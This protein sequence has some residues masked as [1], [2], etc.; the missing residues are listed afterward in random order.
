MVR[1][2]YIAVSISFINVFT[3][4][5][6]VYASEFEQALKKEEFLGQESH[7]SAEQ[8]VTPGTTLN[9]SPSL[10]TGNDID[11]ILEQ[12]EYRKLEILVQ[13]LT[14]LSKDRQLDKLDKL[15][16]SQEKFAS[17]LGV[18]RWKIRKLLGEEEESNI[19]DPVQI[20]NSL[21][22]KLPHILETYTG[23]KIKDALNS[24]IEAEKYYAKKTKENIMQNIDS[25]KGDIQEALT[26]E[27]LIKIID[28]AK[29]KKML[30]YADASYENYWQA[31][32]YSSNKSDSSAASED[33]ADSFIKVEFDKWPEQTWQQA[34]CG[35]LFFPKE[36]ETLYDPIYSIYGREHIHFKL[37]Y[38]AKYNNPLAFYHLYN[39]LQ[40]YTDILEPT[41]DQDEMVE[42]GTLLTVQ[43]HFLDEFKKLAK[44]TEDSPPYI[45]GLFFSWQEEQEKG[46]DWFRKA[47]L[48]KDGRAYYQLALRAETLADRKKHFEE[49]N[50]LNYKKALLGI[51]RMQNN[52]KEAFDKYIEAGKVGIAEGYY[53]TAKTV[54]SYPDEIISTPDEPITKVLIYLDDAAEL[55]MLTAY[56]LAAELC[57]KKD[58]IDD[59]KKYFLKKGHKG[60]PRGFYELGRLLENQ[61]EIEEAKSSYQQSERL[62]GY[63]DAARLESSLEEAEKLEQ[64]AEEYYKSHF[65]KLKSITEKKE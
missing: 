12:Y 39:L 20:W 33:S 57:I 4:L 25:I 7:L 49:A 47:C 26:E 55:G 46:R 53:Q 19:K 45:V 59:A 32:S 2:S 21:K 52:A 35:W 48:N 18:K 43:K 27:G 54:M 31:R 38:A 22:D 63:F 13:M 51:A 34:L 24:Y 23:Q 11:K 62:T 44:Y 50:Q 65:I 29:Y 58:K 3:G 42:E 1:F 9:S 40:L 56:D 60:D 6:S 17:E 5:Y 15:Y 28:S 10:D 64:E 30:A 8:N 16:L 41:D 36:L 61:G 14:K 37:A